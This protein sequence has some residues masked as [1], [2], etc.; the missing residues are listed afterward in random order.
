MAICSNCGSEIPENNEVVLLGKG[1]NAP[2]IIVCSNCATTIE[3]TLRAETQDANL[4]GAVF[5]G[6]GA[7]VVSCLLWYAIVIMTNY[8]VGIVAVAV[9][10]L[11]AQAIV[12][13]AGHKRGVALQVLAVLITVLAMAFSEY[14]IVRHFFVEALA[15]EV[16]ADVPYI[17]PL[18]VTLGLI[19]AGIAAN[20][21]TLLFW[22]I[23]VWEAYA[24]PAERTLRRAIT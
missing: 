1:R 24:I 14:L 7:A 18:G 12:M 22:G 8:E 19:R 9:G 3:E 23:A 11:I 13:G 4:V 17:L 5:W 15:K 6:L 10:W 2:N 20:P 21:L 16:E